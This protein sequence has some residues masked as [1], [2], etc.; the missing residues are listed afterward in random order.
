MGYS[1]YDSNPQLLKYVKGGQ[2]H[3]KMGL[4]VNRGGLGLKKGI[5]AL[6]C[7]LLRAL[8]ETEH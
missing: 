8:I 7:V 5:Q 1:W 6:Y 3:S 2:T 4:L